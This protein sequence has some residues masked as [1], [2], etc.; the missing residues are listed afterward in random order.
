MPHFHKLQSNSEMASF[1]VLNEILLTGHWNVV[2]G[3]TSLSSWAIDKKNILQVDIKRAV[4][5]MSFQCHE[6]QELLLGSL[7]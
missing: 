1:H 2:N 6:N 5:Q 4:V 3:T 7:E